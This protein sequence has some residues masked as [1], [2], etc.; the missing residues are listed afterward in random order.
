M[1]SFQTST[2]HSFVAKTAS[3][4]TVQLNALHMTPSQEK[5]YASFTSGPALCNYKSEGAWYPVEITHV[6]TGGRWVQFTDRTNC[7]PDFERR[8]NAHVRASIAE[9]KPKLPGVA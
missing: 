9:L 1:G 6:D 5:E 3:S 7:P 2:K 4:K 8:R